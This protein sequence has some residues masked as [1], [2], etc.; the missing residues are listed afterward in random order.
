[1]RRDDTTNSKYRTKLTYGYKNTGRQT[2]GQA[3][4][5]STL[6]YPGEQAN[7]HQET[8]RLIISLQPE[9][10]SANYEDIP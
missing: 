10:I 6:T 9:R 4:R 3:N 5:V 2:D 1:M 8:T 7:L